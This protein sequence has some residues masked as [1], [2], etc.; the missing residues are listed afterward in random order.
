MTPPQKSSGRRSREKGARGER[1]A[2]GFLSQWFSTARRG[3]SQT[4]GGAEAPDVDGVPGL[5]VEVKRLKAPQACGWLNHAQH[6][7]DTL[8][9]QPLTPELII[10]GYQPRRGDVPIVLMRGDKDRFVV[11]IDAEWF[12]NEFV[13]ARPWLKNGEEK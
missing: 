4:R 7:L 6:D 9:S 11:A 10:A 2:A 13:A 8:R 5:F 12:F 1:E 3:F